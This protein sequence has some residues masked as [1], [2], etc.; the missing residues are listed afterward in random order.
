MCQP[1][2]CPIFVTSFSD[3]LHFIQFFWSILENQRFTVMYW[4]VHLFV[5]DACHWSLRFATYK[6]KKSSVILLASPPG[7]FNEISPLWYPNSQDHILV[8]TP[9]LTSTFQMLLLLD[10]SFI[11]STFMACSTTALYLAWL[12]E[13]VSSLL[14]HCLPL[15]PFC[16]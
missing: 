13:H 14:I 3:L 12:H 8:F 9:F 15:S 6:E 10:F 1:P 7:F 2:K 11:I 5:S 16:L 4:L